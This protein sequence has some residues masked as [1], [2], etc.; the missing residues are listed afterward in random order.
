MAD[1]GNQI[2][3]KILGVLDELNRKIS[4][5]GAGPAPGGAPGGG[6]APGGTSQ[7]TIT[8]VLKQLSGEGGKKA[9]EAAK[10]IKELSG[11]L[12]ELSSVKFALFG[13][14]LMKGAIGS[15]KQL[16]DF[17]I[18]VGNND[19][20]VKKGSEQLGNLSDSLVKVT[21]VIPKFLGYLALSMLGFVLSLIIIGKIL[22]TEPGRAAIAFAATVITVVG[23]F[24]LVG[25]LAQTDN[26]EKGIEAAKEMGKALG[27]I[28]LGMIVFAMSVALVPR[29]LGIGAG[30][31]SGRRGENAATAALGAIIIFSSVA[32]FA[33]AFFLLGKFQDQITKGTETINEM[34]KSIL[35]LGG[36]MVMFAIAVTLIPRI[37]GIGARAKHQGENAATAAFGA[38]I[39]FSSIALFALA[40]VGLG[41]F[42]E[43]IE[44][45]TSVV[46]Q[47]SFSVMLLSGSMVIF[48]IA[49]ALVPRILG[50]GNKN[51]SKNENAKTA[52]VGALIIFGSITLFALA[53]VGIGML[54]KTG[55]V[56]RGAIT[57]MF[58]AGALILL[59]IGVLIF[60]TTAKAITSLGNSEAGTINKRTG[61]EKGKFGQLMGAI[62][63]GLGA[64]G[65]II[66]SASLLMMGLG[67][68][69]VAGLVGLGA[70]VAIGVSIALITMAKAIKEVAS[71]VQGISADQIE[72]NIRIAVS[73]V[74]KGVSSGVN[75]GFGLKKGDKIN[76]K[77]F[78]QTKRAMR[79]LGDIAESVSKFAQGL[80]AFS[81][82][83]KIA[84]LSYEPKVI[85]K[86]DDGTDIIQM[87]P[88]VDKS[89]TVN[90]TDIAGNLAISLSTFVTSLITSTEDIKK[91]HLKR[92]AK[93]L[94]GKNSI[95]GP[96]A[97]FGELL[98]TY[99][100][101]DKEGNIPV[102]D[103]EGQPVMEN[104]KPKTINITDVATKVAGGFGTFVTS[105]T[106][107]LPD[108][109]NLKDKDITNLSDLSVA[110]GGLAD[111]GEGLEKMST[112]IGSLATNIGLLSTSLKALDTSKLETVS[113]TAGEYQK[114]YGAYTPKADTT[115]T[116]SA[117]TTT[118]AKKENLLTDAEMQTLAQ[119]IGTQMSTA[120]SNKPFT[121][122]FAT[123]ET[124]SGVIQ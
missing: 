102:L 71:A 122:K 46:K 10:N 100:D 26:V 59:S 28:S 63:P 64:M 78:R 79:M 73:S 118:P 105:F 45:G 81:Q 22:A 47:M 111:A 65:I 115:A 7:A 19:S 2:L 116:T 54:D 30:V 18:Y 23:M 15:L 72:G 97:S 1:T 85:G 25:K 95:M 40:F 94:T 61:K 86:D 20:A 106:A 37:L 38:L 104:G 119:Y 60:A 112:A 121:F 48:A 103:S 93:S 5:A 68:P 99:S 98:R 27:Y 108:L 107:A 83:G 124:V 53:F 21:T 75:E 123:G 76:F 3:S 87:V 24:F 91:R 9:P 69:F 4:P 41:I 70:A 35:F 88:V 89:D 82:A 36:S 110:I 84:K 44:K 12:K 33:G 51:E 43:P 55:A 96:I 109:S 32:L 113:K 67:V 17:A 42:K 13:P 90:V 49:L 29:I 57:G 62:G 101:M 39:I 92:L 114:K 77:E 80:Q 31:S 74:I 117:S 120:F 16:V 50:V 6:A 56:K 8:E 52:A 14:M 58:I 66:L 11:A 34:S